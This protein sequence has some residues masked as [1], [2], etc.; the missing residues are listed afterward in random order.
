M[1]VDRVLH[2]DGP[3]CNN[4]VQTADP[5]PYIPI[6]WIEVRQGLHAGPITREFCDW[7]CVMKYAA[8]FPPPEIIPWTSEEPT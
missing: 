8:T 1:A 7:E 4:R 2:C 5:P 3:D 6:G